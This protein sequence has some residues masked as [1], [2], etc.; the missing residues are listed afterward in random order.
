VEPLF[1]G[2]TGK[3]LEAALHESG[4]LIFVAVAPVDDDAWEKIEANLTFMHK[5]LYCVQN[6]D[7]LQIEHLKI[8]HLGDVPKALS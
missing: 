3:T 4:K 5:P 6:K 8:E 1:R 7:F 2:G